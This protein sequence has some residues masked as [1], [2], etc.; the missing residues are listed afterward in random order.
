[1][2][3][4][5]EPPIKPIYLQ[6]KPNAT[7]HLGTT[8]ME[9][10]V[11]GVAY[12]QTARV[13]MRFVPRDRLL[14]FLRPRSRTW[15]T[16]ELALRLMQDHGSHA[17]LPRYGGPHFDVMCLHVKGNEIML[18]PTC[19]GITVTPPTA[20]IVRAVFHILNFPAFHG[21]GDYH[22]VTGNAPHEKHAMCGR[23]LLQADGWR[24]VIAA[25]DKTK[26]LDGALK[27]QGG[28]VITHMGSIEREDGAEFSNDQLEKILESV[29]HLL[30]FALGRWVGV[31]LP[32]GFN[33][34][35]E[36]VFEQWGTPLVACDQWGGA[37]SWFDAPHAEMLSQVFPGFY[38][39]WCDPLWGKA[40]R[41]VLYWYVA[42]NEQQGGIRP[43]E[44]LILAQTALETLAWTY[45]VADRKILS[46]KDFEPE[47]LP[48]AERIRLC[49]G[50]LWIPIPIPAH[51]S[52]LL[53]QK[54]YK[55]KD[56]A[57]AVTWVRNKLVHPQKAVVLGLQQ[58][59]DAWTLAMWLIEMLLLRLCGHDGDYADRRVR[60][61]VPGQVDRVP[62][63]SGR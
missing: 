57:D 12:T 24:I 9:F 60:P 44:G 18:T 25:T 62:W 19:S 37:L 49:A 33:S 36:T 11:D 50:H 23:V 40:L 46:K 8:P 39:G 61:H 3:E 59:L 54:K 5:H 21:P 30:S 16:T 15:R 17:V 42:A 55:L 43:D 10:T 41:S 6:D 27:K 35:N 29:R 31:A 14:F 7:I 38:A 2:L 48:A 28:Y 13:E 45:C 53:S 20:D 47:G 56:A 51:M 26:Q 34:Q 4:L 63:A 22:L 1:M 52:A 58:Y 32:I